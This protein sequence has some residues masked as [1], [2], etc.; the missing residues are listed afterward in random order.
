MPVGSLMLSRR[1]DVGRR[2]LLY[3]VECDDPDDLGRGLPAVL[4]HGREAR[5]TDG[6]NRL[7]IVVATDNRAPV[8]RA[9]QRVFEKACEGDDRLHLHVVDKAA[10]DRL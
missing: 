3:V 2:L 7:R 8:K 5:D 6:Y 4:R 10:T 1:I 9:A